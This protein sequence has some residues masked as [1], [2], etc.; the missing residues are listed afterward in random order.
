VASRGSLP[1][2][3]ANNVTL[4]I[5]TRGPLDQGDASSDLLGGTPEASLLPHRDT[6]VC[7]VGAGCYVAH[8]KGRHQKRFRDWL[9]SRLTIRLWSRFEDMPFHRGVMLL[10]G[11]V[12]GMGIVGALA[13]VP[14]SASQ[15]EPLSVKPA[16]TKSPLPSQSA[17]VT[18]RPIRTVA[19][20]R[21]DDRATSASLQRRAHSD[22]PVP[23]TQQPAACPAT[24]KEFPGAWNYCIQA[25]RSH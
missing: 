5:V 8:M 23:H 15:P 7:F 11:I 4:V 18:P 21:P 14:W 1:G 6:V 22:R 13:L 16:T 3:G 9:I 10:A 24:L 2:L 17:H 20:R 12:T 19:K 25:M